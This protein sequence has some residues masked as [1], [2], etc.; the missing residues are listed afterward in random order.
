MKK[1]QLVE[2]INSRAI[3][4]SFII[5]L[6][7]I[8]L[9]INAF[10]IQIIEGQTNLAVSESVRTSKEII[11]A[12]R[13]LIYD[14]NEKLFVKNNPSFNLYILPVEIQQKQI[15]KNLEKISKYF[16]VEKEKLKKIYENKAF[17][18]NGEIVGERVTLIKGLDYEQYLKHY[19]DIIEM[20][21]FY[22]ISESSRTYLDSKYVAHIL[23]Y[24]GDINAQELEEMNLDP[25]ASV[26]KDG[27]EKVFDHELRGQDGIKI[28]ETNKIEGYEDS[29]WI[30]KSYK[31]G[32]N[33]Y[34]TIDADWQKKLYQL[35]EKHV[36]KNNALGGA[37]VVIEAES[38][39]VRSLVSYPSYDLNSFAKGISGKEF[40]KLLQDDKTPLL[41]R[42]ISMHIPTGSIFKIYMASALQQ[43]Q[44][45]SKDTIFK[46]GCFELSGGYELCEADKKNYGSLNMI[47][48]LARSSN[49][50]FC[51]AT[52]AMVPKFGSDEAS[53]KIL[54]SYFDQF[55]FGKKSLIDLPGAQPGTVP[56]P[57]LK[58]SL[59]NENW[60]L[61]DLCNTAIGQGLVSITPIQIATATAA[62]ANN[63]ELNKPLIVEK[64]EDP[65]MNI[66]EVEAPQLINKV[67][68]ESQYFDNIKEGMRQATQIGSA[69]ILKNSPGN[70]RT[71]TGSSEATI[72]LNSGEIVEGAHSWNT[73]IF[74]YK[75]KTYAYAITLQFGGRGY[76]SVYVTQEFLDWIYSI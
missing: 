32:D 25:K 30:P 58:L 47:Q 15:D 73:G 69:W 12:P 28:S 21:G 3:I 16:L 7:F 1:L 74:D 11:R 4:L 41:N 14:K 38:G 23:G 39:K 49:P 45:I 31:A 48:A 20:P 36:D 19:K 37:A 34:L 66:K 29:T 62:V 67:N 24:L 22:I 65:D 40:N 52:V 70:P 71:K 35:L 68:V 59:Q 6:I 13:G 18:K 2:Q 54:N 46:S 75:N 51:Q 26:G 27:I 56:S 5:V 44:V 63:G 50:Y 64:F 10:R 33:I 72:R 43:E 60:Y 55:G 42:A 57:Q 76:K 17:L 53:I 61:A 8:V 9:S